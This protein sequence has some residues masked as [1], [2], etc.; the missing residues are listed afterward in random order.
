MGWWDGGIGNYFLMGT[1]SQFCKVQE[2]WR[3]MVVFIAQ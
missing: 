2:F 3:W 1:E